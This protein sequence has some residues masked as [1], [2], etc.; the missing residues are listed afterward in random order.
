[1][2]QISLALALA[3]SGC[4]PPL[5]LLFT[6]TRHF[7]VNIFRFAGWVLY[8]FGRGMCGTLCAQRVLMLVNI[9][10]EFVP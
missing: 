4:L 6:L 1:M 3:L 8:L 10:I 5:P 2:W 7:A 9:F